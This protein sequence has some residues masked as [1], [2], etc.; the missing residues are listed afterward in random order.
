MNTDS[1][2]WPRRTSIV[3]FFVLVVAALSVIAHYAVQQKAH[4]LTPFYESGPTHP[5]TE[6][7]EHHAP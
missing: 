1:K 6:N 7:T 5:S 2:R 3:W 4:G